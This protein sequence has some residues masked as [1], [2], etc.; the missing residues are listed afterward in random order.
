[1]A[2]KARIIKL[3]DEKMSEVILHGLGAAVSRTISVALQIQRKLFDT[4]KL[5][6]KTG[7]VKVSKNSVRSYAS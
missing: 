2:Q 5:D 1:M 4:V 6:V 7:T 3:L